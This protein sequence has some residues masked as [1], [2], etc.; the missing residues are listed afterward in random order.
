MSRG[1][2]K[3]SVS[4]KL[5]KQQLLLEDPVNKEKPTQVSIHRSTSGAWC[6]TLECVRSLKEESSA[7]SSAR[8]TVSKACLMDSSCQ[9]GIN[10]EKSLF[11]FQV[12]SS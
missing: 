11:H 12:M 1:R 3:S 7:L 5:K 2:V 6:Q 9:V 4:E 10:S 8:V